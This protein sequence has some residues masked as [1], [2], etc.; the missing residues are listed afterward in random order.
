MHV[1]KRICLLL[2]KLCTVQ[3]TFK[4]AKNVTIRAL[5]N[6]AFNSRVGLM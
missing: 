4:F 6:F 2:G 5:R 1:R 3:L